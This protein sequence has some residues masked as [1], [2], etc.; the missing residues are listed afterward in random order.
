MARKYSLSHKSTTK[1]KTKNEELRQGTNTDK[2]RL[3]E[4]IT[5]IKTETQYGKICH[6]Q[7]FL[8]DQHHIWIPHPHLPQ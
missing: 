7:R 8:H 5:G 1:G 4:T 6:H 3:K 2:E